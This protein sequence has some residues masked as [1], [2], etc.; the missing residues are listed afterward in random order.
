MIYSNVFFTT[1]KYFQMHVAEMAVVS[2]SFELLFLIF[3]CVAY[4]K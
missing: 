3:D 2:Q 4:E 1:T